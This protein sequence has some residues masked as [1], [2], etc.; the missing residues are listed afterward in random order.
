MNK[1]NKHRL[2][3]AT[4]AA[5]LLP[6]VSA[7]GMRNEFLEALPSAEDVTVDVPGQEGQ[8]LALGET[9]D[10]YRTTWNV[11]RGV[12]GGILMVFGLIDRIVRMPPTVSEENFRQWGPSEPQGLE[13]NSFRFTAER[14]E[15]G[16]FVYSLEARPKDSEDDADW[17]VAFDG[18]A[19]PAEG[20]VGNGTLV[21]HFDTMNE[22]NDDC[23]VG[24]ATVDY[25]ANAAD[26]A[27]RAVDVTFDAVANVCNDEDVTFATY[28]YSED[29][30]DGS[31]DFEFSANGDIHADNPDEDKPLLETMT[32]KSR[33][34]SSGTGR[35]DVTIA[36]GE[37]T[38]D[39]ATHLPNS[40]RSDV[41]AT[42]CWDDSFNLTF[43]DTAPEE[44]RDII[45]PQLGDAAE[46]PFA[47]AAYPEPAPA[48]S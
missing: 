5:L 20:N 26:G 43:S 32:I 40:D 23:T 30:E 2:L 22:L 38:S 37:V 4:A 29:K 44:L 6:L 10:F 13:R 17:K 39:I 42:E 46:C 8:A 48:A 28:H 15:E 1:S 33:W 12:N 16:H 7:C 9:S 21:L 41:Q 45:R 11:S 24:T 25:D 47:D 14:V 3:S 31:G 19:Y 35:S 34:L 27:R 18:D 36:G